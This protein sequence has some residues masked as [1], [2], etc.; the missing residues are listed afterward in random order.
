M[1]R[2]SFSAQLP[3]LQ[4]AW[5]STSMGALKRCPRY[6]YYSIVLGWVPREESVHLTFGLRFHECMESYDKAKALGATHHQA[7]RT[8]V[9]TALTNTWNHDLKRPWFSDHKYKNRYTLVRSVIWYLTKF[10]DDPLET[11]VLANGKAAV[12]L[13]WRLELGRVS[14]TGEPVL[15]C[16]HLDRLATWEKNVW[17]VDYKTTY[18]AI[19]EDF[20][21]RYSPDNQFS[22]YS[23]AGKVV[24]HQN[25]QGII[26]NVAQVLVEGTRF[27]RGFV[28]RTPTQL[29]E[30]RTDLDWWISLAEE[31]AKRGY[32][33]QNDMACGLF[34]GCAYRKICGK[35][36]GV[37]DDW[38][39]ASYVQRSW[40][41]LKV[42]GDI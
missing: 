12:E 10:A 28:V 37:R 6:Y 30:W 31:C 5:D 17:I 1:N 42:R 4:V 26:A 13:S 39:R 34:G 29:E 20:F 38:L 19:N 36:P 3:E 15:A 8:A 33:P 41:P 32:W 18:T 14:F 11:V 23:Y 16:G 21:D 24:Y 40:D 9:R 22:T 27:Q 2:L 35:S 25:I 7:L